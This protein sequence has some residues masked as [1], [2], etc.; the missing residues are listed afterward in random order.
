MSPALIVLVLEALIVAEL[1]Y[2]LGPYRRRSFVVIAV[3]TAVGVA[4]GQLWAN[5]GLPAW[6]LGEADLLPAVAFALLLQALH[7]VVGRLPIHLP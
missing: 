5:A 2:A 4:A 1:L 7:P 6:K 3:L